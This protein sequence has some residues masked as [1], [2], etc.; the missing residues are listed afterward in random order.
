ML[1]TLPAGWF[2]KLSESMASEADDKI[3]DAKPEQV[4]AV[5]E[6][7]AKVPQI[8]L[9]LRKEYASDSEGRG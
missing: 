1:S 4:K 5:V 7:A 6:E 9:M 3:G 2:T 8:M